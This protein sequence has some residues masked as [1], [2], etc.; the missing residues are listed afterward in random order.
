MKRLANVLLVGAAACLP[1]FNAHAQ[2][3]PNKPVKFILSQPAGA[4]P[5]VVARFVAEHLLRRLGSR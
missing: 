4:G 2:V 1:F 3:R 5:D